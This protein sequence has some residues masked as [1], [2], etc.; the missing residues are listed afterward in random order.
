MYMSIED[1][2]RYEKCWE[3]SIGLSFP[4][5]RVVFRGQD[6][7]SEFSD[8]SWMELLLYGITGK[9]FSKEQIQLFESIW[10]I[11]TSYP[12][13]RI[14]NNRVSALA[15]TA[16]ST[17]CLAV[18]ASNA[19]SEALL[20][21]RRPDI[22]AIDFL[23]RAQKKME[24]GNDLSNVI[25]SELKRHRAI[26]GYARPIVKKDERITP[27][28]NEASKL[29]LANGK[30]LKLV[31]LVED[32]L[33][34]GRWRKKA[35]IAAVAAGLA[36]DLGLSP[37]EYYNYLLVSFSIGFIVCYIDAVDKPENAFFPY[38]CKRILY[39][40]KENRNW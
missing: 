18:G 3:T 2:L 28:I 27:L 16:R 21:G 24:E 10:T 33:D 9:K 32:I 31:Y 11:S 14:W 26:F 12:D 34:K 22:R 20:Y 13:P 5:E 38:S 35:N 1:L 30:Y 40:G 17:A 29:G 37:R 15:G 39:A 19:M 36:A 6:L 7:F 25:S 8:K 4:G 23:Y